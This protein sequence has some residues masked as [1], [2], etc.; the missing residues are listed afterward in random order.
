[1]VDGST[2]SEDFNA[3]RE[4]TDPPMIETN[5]RRDELAYQE[6][7]RIDVPNLLL[8]GAVRSSDPD[9]NKVSVAV[10]SI[11]EPGDLKKLLIRYF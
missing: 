2:L 7:D 1:M 3:F 10:P 5:S 4:V 11:S 9:S 8:P 6:T